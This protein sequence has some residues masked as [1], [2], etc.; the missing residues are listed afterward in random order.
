L[1]KEKDVLANNFFISY[2]PVNG[3]FQAAYVIVAYFTIE[4]AAQAW[5]F[6]ALFYFYFYKTHFSRKT[7]KKTWL[8]LR[9]E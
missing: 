4:F 1:S 7:C 5:T 6:S 9:P 2:N 8:F 3:K